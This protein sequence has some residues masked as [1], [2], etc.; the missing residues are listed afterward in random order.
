MVQVVYSPWKLVVIHE[1]SRYDSV[2]DLIRGAFAGI[3]RGSNVAIRWVD[4]VDGIALVQNALPMTDTLTKELIEGR[5]YWDHVSFAPMESYSPQV[6][7]PDMRVTATIVD[8]STND[9]FRAIAQFL[10]RELFR[11]GQ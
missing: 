2:Q 7:L 10:K 5:L 11:E 9:V 3:P 8:V 4:G 6:Y 1:Y